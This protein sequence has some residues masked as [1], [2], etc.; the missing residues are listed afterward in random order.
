MNNC[1]DEKYNMAA[2]HSKFILFITITWDNRNAVDTS[3]IS[4]AWS[5]LI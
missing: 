1:S 5:Q 4:V 3:D 2:V